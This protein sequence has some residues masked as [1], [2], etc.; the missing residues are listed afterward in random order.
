MKVSGLGAAF[1]QRRGTLVRTPKQIPHLHGDGAP[2]ADATCLDW[3]SDCCLCFAFYPLSSRENQLCPEQ[4]R[5]FVDG[6]VL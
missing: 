2:E 6:F 1:G 3:K 4:E 5:G